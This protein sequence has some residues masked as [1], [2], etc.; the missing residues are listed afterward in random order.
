MFDWIFANS[1]ID[2]NLEGR[3][4]LSESY[5]TLT[6]KMH[7]SNSTITVH[8][9]DFLG[10]EDVRTFNKKDINYYGSN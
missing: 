2:H 1:Y 4:Y 5:D 9:M 8:V 10:F 3:L 7:D 6:N